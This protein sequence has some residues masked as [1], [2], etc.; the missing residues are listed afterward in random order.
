MTSLVRP[1]YIIIIRLVIRR[2][3]ILMLKLWGLWFLVRL[4]PSQRLRQLDEAESFRWSTHTVIY[5]RLLVRAIPLLEVGWLV[6]KKLEPFIVCALITSGLFRHFREIIVGRSSSQS[7]RAMERREGL[8]ASFIT[9]FLIGALLDIIITI[10]F[11]LYR[12]V[13]LLSKKSV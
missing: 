8:I 11:Y 10:A 1:L 5:S 9:F 3:E 7:A 6:I 12:L 4:L 13:A 2:R